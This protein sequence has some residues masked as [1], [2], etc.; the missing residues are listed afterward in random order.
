MSI[1][2]RIVVAGIALWVLQSCAPKVRLAAFESYDA[3]RKVYRQKIAL[4]QQSTPLASPHEEVLK[5]TRPDT[6]PA[7]KAAG[8]VFFKGTFDELLKAAKQQRKG[9]MIDF[10]ATWC[11]P[12]KQMDK[13][14]FANEQV[15]ELAQ[16]SFLAYKVDIDWFEGMDIAD[17]YRVVQFPTVVF[18]DSDGRYIDRVKG[19]YAPDAFA[20]IMQ[21]MSKA[22]GR[23]LQLSSL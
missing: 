9:V 11:G 22:K 14:T 6:R 12:C 15:G 10:M 20:K 1:N 19:F 23:D 4:P 2:N 17:R 16:Q 18:L 21:Q 7:D 13:E 8:V 3:P 5:P